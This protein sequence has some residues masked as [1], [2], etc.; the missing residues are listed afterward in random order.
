MYFLNVTIYQLLPTPYFFEACQPPQGLE[1]YYPSHL[2]D[3]ETEL[4]QDEVSSPGSRGCKCRRG[5]GTV[6]PSYLGRSHSYASEFFQP[7]TARQR[8]MEGRRSL[9]PASTVISSLPQGKVGDKGSLG[10]PGPPGPEVC[11]AVFLS[12]A[13]I[14]T[15]C[16][17][18]ETEIQRL[19]GGGIYLRPRS[20]R[21][22]RP[23][24]EILRSEIF[25][26][27]PL[28]PWWLS[29]AVGQKL[30]SETLPRFVVTFIVSRKNIRKALCTWA[31]PLSRS[32]CFSS[33]SPGA[34][35][36]THTPPGKSSGLK[37]PRNGEQEANMKIPVF[38]WRMR[39]HEG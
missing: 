24:I 20:K 22:M 21:E 31:C 11:E 38:E 35:P 3:G 12:P 26:C 9:T 33:L 7:P 34:F 23:R 16:G 14:G 17:P 27:L 29:V 18:W 5:V 4:L 25:P 19:G 6:A 15:G 13:T 32:S 37:V 36:N 2:T 8:T 39:N 10:F 30:A 1:Y 28:C